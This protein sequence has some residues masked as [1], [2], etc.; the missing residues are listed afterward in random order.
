MEAMMSVGL[1]QTTEYF[2]E[3]V[4]WDFAAASCAGDWQRLADLYAPDAKLLLSD[5]PPSNLSMGARC[6]NRSEIR[7]TFER[8]WQNGNGP[9]RLEILWVSSSA[10][11]GFAWVTTECVAHAAQGGNNQRLR[12]SVVLEERRARWYIV[13]QHISPVTG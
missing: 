11:E 6:F 12:M 7:S 8:L 13:Q 9:A 1:E 2:V 3:A 5:W 10:R 4:L